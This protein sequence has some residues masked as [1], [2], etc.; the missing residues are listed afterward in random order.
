MPITVI[1]GTTPANTGQ[2]ATPATANFDIAFVSGSYSASYAASSATASL[3]EAAITAFSV[4][5][6]KLYSIQVQQIKQIQQIPFTLMMYHL[7]LVLLTLQL[8]PLRYLMLV[9]QQLIV[10]QYI[11]HYKVLQVLFQLLLVY[12]SL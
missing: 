10:L 12:C 9:L 3:R 6:V 7:I 4:E 1:S 11:Q 8:L 2:L 5:G